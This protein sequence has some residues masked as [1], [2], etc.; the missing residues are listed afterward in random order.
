MK[1][2]PQI[3]LA[4]WYARIFRPHLT[5]KRWRHEWRQFLREL[6]AQWKLSHRASRRIILPRSSRPPS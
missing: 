1:D 5:R 2:R 3:Q 4:A 6:E